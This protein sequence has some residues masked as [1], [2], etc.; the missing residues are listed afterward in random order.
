MPTSRQYEDFADEMNGHIEVDKKS[1]DST[2]QFI[3]SEFEPDDIFSDDALRKYVGKI[4][5]P[6]DVFEEKELQAWAEENG[7]IKE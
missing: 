4:S 7:Y 1:L 3:A 5:L 2:L 6:Q